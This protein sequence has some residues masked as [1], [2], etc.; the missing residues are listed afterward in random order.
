MEVNQNTQLKV[1][2]TLGD[3]REFKVAKD[4][5]DHTIQEYGKIDCLVNAAGILVG[6]TVLDTN[7]AE[8][9]KQFDVNVRRSVGD[10]YFNRS[11]Q[12]CSTDPSCY[13][14]SNQGKGNHCQRIICHWTVS[15][16]RSH[17]LL[18]VEGS[19]R[20]VHEMSCS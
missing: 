11:F 14:S 12:R 13:S 4:L 8:Y 2:S 15:I 9:D 16:S 5:I 17:L 18:H 7:L 3:L 6:G 1:K 20:P 19:T 10:S